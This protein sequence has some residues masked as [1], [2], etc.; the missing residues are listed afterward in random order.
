MELQKIKISEIKPYPNNA[1]LHTAEQLGK[2]RDSIISFGYNDPIALDESNEIIEGHGR[3]EALKQIN[4][5]QEIDII[6]LT[7]LTDSQKKAYRIAHNKLNMITDFDFDILKEEFHSLEDTD[8]FNDTGFDVSEI[9][10]IWDTK[11]I[12]FDDVPDGEIPEGLDESQVRMVQL[13]FDGPKYEQ[14]MELINEASKKHKTDNITDT[15]W[16]ALNENN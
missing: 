14:F 11:K 8:N 6:R 13:F 10:D 7:G 5:D 15:V 1:K 16:A 9:S 2:I 3:L 12:N 4:P